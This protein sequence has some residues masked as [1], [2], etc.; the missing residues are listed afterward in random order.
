MGRYIALA[1]A[2]AKTALAYRMPFVLS[3]FGVL[4]QYVAMLAV[5][6][7]LLENSPNP[8]MT[9]PQMRSYLLIAFASGALVGI[10]ADFGMANRIQSGMV[11]L[12]LVKPVRYQEARFAEVLGAAWIEL[13]VVVVVGAGTAVSGDGLLFPSGAGLPLFLVSLVLLIP[14]KFIVL[15][16]CGLA[17]FWTQSYVGIQ[18]ARIAVVNLLSGALVPLAFLPGWLGTIA[19]WSPFAGMASTPGLIFAGK[20]HGPAAV[21]LVAA[22]FGWLVVLWT[23]AKLLWGR[24]VRQLTVNGG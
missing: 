5:W 9:W 15:Y 3:L 20:A 1:R 18:W 4:F 24:A 13:A 6:R 10:F 7:A 12:D 14:L 22:Q 2:S 11:A 17:V 8:A 23:A 16:I 19:T 21:A